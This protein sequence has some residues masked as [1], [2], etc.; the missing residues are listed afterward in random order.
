MDMEKRPEVAVQLRVDPVPAGIRVEGKE[1]GVFQLEHRQGRQ[2]AVLKCQLAAGDRIL[3]AFKTCGHCCR[4]SGG[5]Q[6]A[7]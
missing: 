6:V 7:A 1:R 4:H 5:T 2:Q 3:K